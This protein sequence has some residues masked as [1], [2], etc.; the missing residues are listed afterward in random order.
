M[1]GKE[2]TAEQRL[3]AKKFLEELDQTEGTLWTETDD[4]IIN[5]FVKYSN[6]QNATL[7]SELE[8]ARELLS[9]LLNKNMCSVLGDELINTF[10]NDTKK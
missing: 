3:E 7:H 6:K 8:K 2:I 9:T 10:F 1:E 5:A 4:E